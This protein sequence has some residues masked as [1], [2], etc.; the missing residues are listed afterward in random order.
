VPRSIDSVET[1]ADGDGPTVHSPIFASAE[2]ARSRTW[3][4]AF[5]LIVGVGLGFAAGYTY[6]DTGEP[7]SAP[8][9][10]ATTAPATPPGAPAPD[11]R[12]F[13]ESAVP[14]DRARPSTGSGRAVEP[15]ADAAAS[16]PVAPPEKA[17]NVGRLLVRST[18]AGAAVFLNGRDVGRTP[19]ALRD[20]DTGTHSLR[21]VRDGYAPDERRVVLT[22]QRPVQSIIMTLEPRRGAETSAPADVAETFEKYSGALVVESRPSG[23]SVFIDNQLRGTTPL[24]IDVIRAG[25][26]ALRLEYE[27]YRRWTAQVRIVA[28]EQGR[29]TASLER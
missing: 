13:T 27:G 21:V 11:K 19:L 28:S 5:I 24:S 9:P 12:E 17:A 15:K 20:L 23:A 29:V 3:P 18:P 8:A 16:T 6:R 25:E 10:P 22:A 14:D 4:M 7:A 26:H 1:V 2:P